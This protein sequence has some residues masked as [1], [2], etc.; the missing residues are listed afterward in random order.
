MLN[1]AMVCCTPAALVLHLDG[2][3]DGLDADLVDGDL[4]GVRGILDVRNGGGAAQVVMTVLKG[5]VGEW[6]LGPDI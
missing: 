1:S 3:A 5:L 4:A 6:G 2:V